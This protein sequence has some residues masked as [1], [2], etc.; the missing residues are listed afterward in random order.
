M[1]WFARAPRAGGETN[2][3]R[4]GGE[5]GAHLRRAVSFRAPAIL[6]ISRKILRVTDRTFLRRIVPALL[7]AAAAWL[8][9]AAARAQVPQWEPADTTLRIV[10]LT[11]GPGDEVWEK[12]GH[13]A[14]WVHDPESGSDLAYNYGMFDFRQENFVLNFARG[15]MLYWMDGVDAYLTL[16]HYRML[17][18]SVW[19]QELNLTPAQAH[20][21][22]DFLR[23]NALPENRFYRYDYYRDNCST[24]VRDVID[25]VLGGALRRATEGSS[26]VTY[27]WHTRRLTAE[28]AA[29]LPIHSAIDAGL[30]PAA[31]R[32]I[33]KWDE[34]FLPMRLRDEAAA[35]RIPSLAG[36]T[37]PL[38]A[39]Q[40][41]VFEATRPPERTEPPHWL[42]GYL[43]A[44]LALGGA[45]YGLATLAPRSRVARAGFAVLTIPW[46]LFAGLGGI[47]LLGLWGLTDHAIAY[48]NVNLF[49]LS[50]VALPLVVLVPALGFGSLRWPRITVRWTAVVVA[51][52]VAGLLLKV[53]PWF[54][55]TNG[56]WIALA[57]PIHLAIFASA[58]RLAGAR[59]EAV[60]AAG[61]KPKRRAVP[62]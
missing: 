1:G 5:S 19:A 56:E 4:G 27:R 36:G 47:I 35:L 8:A 37:M 28:G 51:L 42:F 15:R 26:G 40:T 21:V 39:R 61:P 20:E 29:T 3:R 60:P 41:T 43:L 9:P 24:R 25:R 46:L 62:A 31:D 55:Q 22:R 12:F 49:Q 10:L 58:L 6:F 38:V 53:L 17:N 52:S 44:G 50:P 14:L 57:L 13:N 18:R 7:L 32:P 16:D 23:N 48:R 11:M 54:H 33:S 45:I 34:M 2:A 59:R 30:G